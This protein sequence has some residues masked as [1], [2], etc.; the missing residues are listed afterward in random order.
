MNALLTMKEGSKQHR[1][2]L[3]ITWGLF[4]LLAIAL[5]YILT[6]MFGEF[7][8]SRMNRA[9]FMAVAILGLNLVI[10]YSGLIALG[11]SAFIGIGA[12]V[13]TTLVQDHN[14]DY[15]MTIPASM[16]AC[17]FVGVL[18]G[19]PALRIKGLYLALVTVTFAVVFPT[20]AKIDKWTI[21]DRTG[22]VNGRRIDEKVAAPTWVQ[23]IL[24]IDDTPDQQV[25]YRYF[26]IAI[27]TAI[28]F[29]LVRNLIKSRPGRAIVAIRDNETGAAV[30]GIN[31]PL[32]KVMTFGV[33]A[34]FGGLAGMMW[35]MDRAFVAEQDFTFVLAIDL[36]VGLVIGG[37]ATLQGG[38]AGALVVVFV[39]EWTKG[40]EIPLGFTTIDGGGPLSQAIFGVIL[41]FVTFFAPGGLV[42]ALRLVK[43]KLV[44]VIPQPPEGVTPFARA[45][46]AVEEAVV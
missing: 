17:F 3:V 18:L 31:L 32:Y 25:I 36:L 33:S 13:T 40:L 30:S 29:A 14:W 42:S 34:S 1:T 8:V 2:Y 15:W 41:I 26:I 43:N 6:A 19:I 35:A 16:L 28:T 22:G 21:S 4:V 9:L 27:L 20:L 5:P 11:H 7:Q 44:R 10:G 45:A 12:F 24:G 38:L 39:R 23:N 46:D 37:V